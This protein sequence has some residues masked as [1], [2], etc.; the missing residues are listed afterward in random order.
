LT[1]EPGGLRELH[2]HANA[3]EWA[4]VIEG[5]CRVTTIDPENQCE[6][7]D[8][9]PGDVWYFPRGH[10]HS[11]QGLGPGTCTFV[12]VF[13]NGYFSEFGTFSITDWIGHTPPEVLAKTFNLPAETFADFP[14]KEVYIARGPVP[15]PLPQEPAPG[16]LDAPPLTYAT[17][18]SRKS[19]MRLPAARCAR[20]Q[21]RSS[22]SRP[23]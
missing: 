15:P 16:S 5:R 22:R 18:C 21:R 4:Y 19:Q 17:S 7:V 9:G 20:C 23:P 8:F 1:L 2:W 3:A 10:G 12:L 14:K 13:D 11:I 6:I